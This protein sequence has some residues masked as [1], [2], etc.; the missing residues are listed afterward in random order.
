[1]QTKQCRSLADILSVPETADIEFE[2]PRA[3][4]VTRQPDFSGVIMEMKAINVQQ[5]RKSPNK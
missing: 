3:Y 5:E 1:M 2:P 4:I